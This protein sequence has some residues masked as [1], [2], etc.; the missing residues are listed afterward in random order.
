MSTPTGEG[1]HAAGPGVPAPARRRRLIGA[2]L[3]VLAVLV[4]A[5]AALVVSL[6]TGDSAGP[7]PDGAAGTPAGT[8][9]STPAGTTAAATTAPAA[10][11]PTTVPAAATEPA[12]GPTEG[13]DATPSALPEV[14]LDSPA[15]VGNGVVAT[16][17]AIEAIEGAAT[18]PGNV[19]GPA[20]RVT[21]RIAN[22]TDGPVSLDGVATNLSYG[23]DRTPAS[24]LDDPSEQPFSG[25]LAAGDQAEAVYVFSVPAD[26]RDVVTV[27]VG[28]TAGAPLLLFTGPVS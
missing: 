4:A 9:A 11:T 27:E 26:V 28:Y 5:L 13:G 19:N 15:A 23:P 7:V 14:A 6:T 24:P 18:G 22:G 17:P 25:T 21:V 2:V 12:V 10:P 1:R 3:A 16:L 20:L 8:T